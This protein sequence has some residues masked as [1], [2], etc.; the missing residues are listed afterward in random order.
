MFNNIFFSKDIMIFLFCFPSAFMPQSLQKLG[1]K[2]KKEKDFFKLLY[3]YIAL[4]AK[5]TGESVKSQKKI[6]PIQHKSADSIL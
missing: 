3:L 1:E 6:N 2:K 5:M 4:A